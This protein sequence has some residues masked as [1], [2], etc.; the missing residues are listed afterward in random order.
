MMEALML[1]PVKQPHSFSLSHALYNHQVNLINPLLQSPPSGLPKQNEHTFTLPLYKDIKPLAHL[2]TKQLLALLEETIFPL[3]QRYDYLINQEKDLASST[4]LQTNQEKLSQLKQIIYQGLLA[5]CQISMALKLPRQFDDV[6]SYFE[7]KK[8]PAL[9]KEDSLDDDSR[10]L[11]YDILAA[12]GFNKAKLYSAI[13]DVIPKRTYQKSCDAKVIKQEVK[14]VFGFTQQVCEAL[15][16]KRKKPSR[17]H[18]FLQEATKK[19]EALIGAFGMQ[20]LAN[21]WQ[22]RYIFYF[23]LSFIAYYLLM[24]AIT[25][26]FVLLL[27][28]QVL[29]LISSVLFYSIALFPLWGIISQ[30]LFFGF[31][32]FINQRRDPKQTQIVEALFFLEQTQ[33]FISYRL[34]QIIVDISHYDIDAL[35]QMILNKRLSISELKKQ[36]LRFNLL[37]KVVAGVALKNQAKVVAERLVILEGSLDTTVQALISHMTLRVEEER[38]LLEAS[39]YKQTLVPSFPANQFKKISEFIHEF[40]TKA[41]ISNFLKQCHIADL[42]QK[43]FEQ[44][45]FVDPSPNGLLQ[46]PFGKHILRHD[47]MKGWQI[48]LNAWHDGSEKS[49]SMALLNN[50]I[51]GKKLLTQKALTE[52]IEQVAQNSAAKDLLEK[53][54]SILFSTLSQRPP[55]TAALLSQAQKNQIITWHSLHRSPIKKAV[56]LLKE[57]FS[58]N[59]ASLLAGYTNIE[60]AQFYQA[61]EGRDY[62]HFAKGHSQGK[63]K[64]QNQLRVYFERYQGQSSHAFLLMRFLPEQKKRS[65]IVD[66]AKHRLAWIISHLDKGVNPEKPFDAQDIELFLH[67]DLLMQHSRFNVV[68]AICESREFKET[69]NPKM[70][71]FLQSCRRH[72]LDTGQLH[73]LYLNRKNTVKQNTILAQYKHQKIKIKPFPQNEFPGGKISVSRKIVV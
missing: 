73:L 30:K 24:Q 60:L 71:Q 26:A 2:T 18:L 15:A 19:S 32:R 61:L 42:W 69:Y 56:R 37:D 8:N 43:G 63:S 21:F 67:H 14:D 3:E 59:A 47:M 36:L 28:A 7:S 58:D 13:I 33:Q 5:R 35:K 65:M 48:L 41:Q 53:I 11:I 9:V 49:N 6:Q 39:L 4:I 12:A 10:I 64:R 20:K 51:S 55:E 23:L 40:G 1:E 34:N 54:Q 52:S 25:T 31:N 16:I 46:Q 66:V 27:S 22:L 44:L 29:T 17:L 72:G 62:Y 70:D 45:T 68:E 38:T 50:L 57:V